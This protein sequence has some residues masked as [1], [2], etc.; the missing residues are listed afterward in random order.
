MRL[1]MLTLFVPHR[2]VG[3]GAATVDAHYV[4]YFGR[5][6]DLTVAAFTFNDREAALA[7]EL[8]GTG[9]DVRTVPFPDT[10]LRR[11]R[12]RAQSLFGPTPFLPRLFNR[13]AMASMLGALFQEKTFDLVQ[14]ETSFLGEYLPLVPADAVR[15]LMELDVSVK[16]LA[17]RYRLE[18][19]RLRRAWHRQQWLQMRRYEPALCRRVDRVY[20]VSQEDR[21]LLG[22][23]AGIDVGLFRYGVDPALLSVPLKMRNDHR[24]L[25]L[26]AFLHQPNVHGLEWFAESVLPEARR[27]VPDLTFW[28]VGRNPPPCAQALARDPANRVLG[29]VP[30]VGDALAQVDVGVV[31][32]LS[33]G[34]VKLKTLEML[35]AGKAV[36]TT[37]IGIEGIDA[38]DGEHL[39]VARTAQEF[40]DKLVRLLTDDHLRRQLGAKGRELV[41]RDHQWGSNLASLE[42]EYL[43]L[44]GGAMARTASAV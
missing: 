10:T 1:L 22:D 36:V 14:I 39:L 28:C 27:R 2:G 11:M 5:R 19:S 7:R 25:F 43:A 29:W 38:R 34:G 17:R 26:G 6:H 37:P 42:R 30:N 16:P 13:P 23:L 32:L 9:V 21:A 40:A 44:T 41:C 35:A 4:E 20:A 33:G 3:H 8:A 15:V 24:A 31:P 18:R 12:A